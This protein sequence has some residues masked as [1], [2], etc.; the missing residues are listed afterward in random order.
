[1]KQRWNKYVMKRLDKFGLTIEEMEANDVGEF[2]AAGY[3]VEA[4][5]TLNHTSL[6]GYRRNANY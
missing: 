5:T 1:M 6:R 3:K 2:T 4:Y